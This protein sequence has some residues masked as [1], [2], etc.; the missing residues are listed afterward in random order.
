M[1]RQQATP[2]AET[3]Y[4]TLMKRNSV[5][6]AFIL[7]GALAGERAVNYTFDQIWIANNKGKR[8]EDIPMLGKRVAE[9]E[10]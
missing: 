2:I 4:R 8:Y 10:E 7:V 9:A 1:E 6:I 3:I 5:Y